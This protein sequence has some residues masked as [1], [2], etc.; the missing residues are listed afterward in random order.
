MLPFKGSLNGS[1]KIVDLRFV[2]TEQNLI[3]QIVIPQLYRYKTRE[4]LTLWNFTE[5]QV[6]FSELFVI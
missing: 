3:E 1:I 5:P 6:I 4:Y 2:L